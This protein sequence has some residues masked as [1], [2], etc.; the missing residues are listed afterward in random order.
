MTL[1]EPLQFAPVFV[2]KVWGGRSLEQY[3][4]PIDAPGPIGEVWGLVDRDEC[5]SVVRGGEFEGRNLRGL[6]LSESESLL[7][8]TTAAT[9]EYFP[10]LVKL[11]D[12]TQDLSV[13][14]HPDRR[15]ARRIGGGAAGKTEAWFILSA[16]PG[17][18]IQLGL[19]P[20]VDAKAFAEKAATPEVVDLLQTH[21]VKPGQFILVPPGTVHS[22]G[23]GITLVEIQENSDTTYRLFDWGRVGM[24]G[25]PR[26]LH[27]EQALCSMDYEQVLV[28]PVESVISADSADQVRL[29][30]CDAFAI[31]ILRLHGSETGDTDGRAL[32]YVVV[33]GS[34]VL[35]TSGGIERRIGRGETWL[36][37]ASIGEH[38]FT[39]VDGELRVL[40]VETRALAE[41]GGGE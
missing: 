23:R 37:P 38:R 14:V 28:G 13:Q 35:A 8:A 25:E 39:S 4:G 15:A 7:G 16:E 32:V 12:A 6:M 31:D 41:E 30:D 18:T 5:S 21:E 33:E 29:V 34:G 17:S 2:P 1:Q 9:G 26:E 24:D 36:L 10:L 19:Q 22:I 27:T 11:L 3:L 20:G 40:R